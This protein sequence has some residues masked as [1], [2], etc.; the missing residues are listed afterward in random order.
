MPTG[1]TLN[2]VDA[3]GAIVVAY[4][5]D[6]F[7][8]IFLMGQETVYLTEAYNLKSFVSKSGENL[9][10]TFLYKGTMSDPTDLSNAKTKFTNACIEIM[11]IKKNTYGHVTF[12]D[13]KNSSSAPGYISGKP[14]C[15]KE[16]KRSAFGFT[17]GGYEPGEDASINDTV[18]RECFQET[19]VKLD[20]S[21]LKELE[22]LHQSSG[23]SKYALF[24]YEF[25]EEE[26]LKIRDEKTIQHKN[27]SY[28]NELHNI[29]FNRI[30]E[31]AGKN[32]FINAISKKAYE[33]ANKFITAK[34][35]GASKNTRKVGSRYINRANISTLRK[36][37]IWFEKIYSKT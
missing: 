8:P 18:I 20:I 22:G 12:A 24:M 7:G 17:K 4:Y 2:G 15:V 30:P 10:Q 28:E 29:K 27:A 26:Y 32:F 14:R 1:K 23:D 37:D 36:G 6:R 11:G 21:K 16:N 3:S 31:Q 34:K 25:S 13:L 19:G 9:W 35:G 5:K 33:K